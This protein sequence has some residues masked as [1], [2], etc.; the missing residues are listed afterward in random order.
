MYTEVVSLA[1]A[2]HIMQRDIA[3]KTTAQLKWNSTNTQIR[4]KRGKKSENKKR[5]T[6][7]NEI[8]ELNPS[9]ATLNINGGNE[10][11]DGSFGEGPV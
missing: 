1:T 7:H 4:Q 10:E 11:K 3:K 9:L 8:I 2:I 6:K 5:G